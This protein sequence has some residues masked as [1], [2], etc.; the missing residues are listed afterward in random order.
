MNIQINGWLDLMRMD[1]GLRWVLG[2][3]TDCKE[4]TVGAWLWIIPK[5]YLRGYDAIY[6]AFRVLVDYE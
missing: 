4:Q 1:P 3:A 2:N 5:I 6:Y